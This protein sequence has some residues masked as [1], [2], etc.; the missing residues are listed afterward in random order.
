[1][2]KLIERIL[3]LIFGL[4]ALFYLGIELY[5]LM[6]DAPGADGFKVMVLALLL[7]IFRCV[8]EKNVS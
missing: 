6:T 8:R 5:K 1:M 4:G 2:L 7:G 3:D